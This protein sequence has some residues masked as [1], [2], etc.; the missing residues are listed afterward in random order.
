ME[1]TPI[2]VRRRAAVTITSDPLAAAA[3]G[4][5]VHFEAMRFQ[6]NI[7]VEAGFGSIEN[8]GHFGGVVLGLAFTEGARVS[9]QG[10]AVMVAPGI[11]VTATHT[12]DPQAEALR[13]S[14]T[15]CVAFGL[16][17][18]AAMFWRLRGVTSNANSDIAI[19]SLEAASP[20]PDRNVYRQA[21][22]T[23]RSPQEGETVTVIGFRF[24]DTLIGTGFRGEAFASRGKVVTVYDDKRD[25]ALM[26]W[27]SFEI[28]AHAVGGMSGGPVFDSGGYLVGLLSSSMSSESNDGPAFASLLWPCLGLP[29]V[30]TW[31]ADLVG[32]KKSLLEIDPRLCLIDGRDAVSF[33]EAPG[34]DRRLQYR[35]WDRPESFCN[36]SQT[37]AGHQGIGAPPVHRFHL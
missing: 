28:S 15:E 35:H 12:L 1:T 24:E 2:G 9:V 37:G 14:R 4:S 11:A 32:G 13:E 27:P 30:P 5:E 18:D 21:W 3:V 25:S 33:V 20:L 6:M 17:D 29:F 34:G 26:R 22:I 19:L 31:P 10:T 36:G 16:R 23:T 7:G 8:W